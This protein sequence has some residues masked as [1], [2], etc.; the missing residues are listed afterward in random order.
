ME[1]LSGRV[2][3]VP[4]IRPVAGLLNFDFIP[5]RWERYDLFVSKEHFFE[6]GLSFF[7]VF[8]MS[9]NFEI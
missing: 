7:W 5:L 9:L 1:V 3:A 6:R 8:F 2:A 4:A